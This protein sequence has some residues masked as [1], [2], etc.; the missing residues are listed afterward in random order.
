MGSAQGLGFG[1]SL[2]AGLGIGGSSMALV[3]GSATLESFGAG[4]TGVASDQT[5][6]ALAAAA[7]LAGTAKTILVGGAS[8]LGTWG[9]AV[10]SSTTIAG[11]GQQSVIKVT[12]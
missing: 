3:A 7:L 10:P 11:Q 6:I 5:A 1:L 9:F 2:S 12:G 4:G 8:Y